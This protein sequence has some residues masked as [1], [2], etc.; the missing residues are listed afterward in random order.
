MTST[1]PTTTKKEISTK[2]P[3]ETKYLSVLDGKAKMAYVE[4]GKGDPILFLHGNP[5]SKYLWRNIMPYLEKSGGHVVAVDLIGMG[6]SDKPEDCNYRFLDH[7][8]YLESFIQTKFNLKDTEKKKKLTLVIHDW[9]SALGFHYACC[10]PTQIKGI[11][12][13]EAIVDTMSWSNFPTDYKIGFTLMRTPYIGSALVQGLNF[14][15]KII[16]PQA[17]V[18]TLTQEE[19]DEYAKPFPT[20]ASRKPT[21]V[22][23]NEI[24]IDE[25]PKDNY[26]IVK[27]Y[28]RWLKE[29]DSKD[30]PKLM[31]TAKPGGII[32]PELADEIMKD[33]PNIKRVDMTTTSGVH[34]IQEDDPHFIGEEI[35]KWYS[36]L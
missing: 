11:A 12:F 25:Y 5:T 1:T 33:I 20:F 36:E 31:I 6:E 21:Y 22:W 10:N 16:L 3:Y 24:P 30:I 4:A 13:M 29:G 26:D 7:Y 2:M 17:I 8:Q 15:V 34:F 14:F 28:N 35:S 23:P 32:T 19:K 9:G 27:R 18:R